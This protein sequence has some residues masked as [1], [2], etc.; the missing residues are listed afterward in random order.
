MGTPHL[1]IHPSQ[2]DLLDLPWERSITEWDDPRLADLPTGIHRHEIVFIGLDDGF[3]AIKELPLL[4]A[5]NEY[6]VLS[7]LESSDVPSVQ[8]IGLVEREWLDPQAE[9]S[10]AVIT[11][12]LAHAFSYRELISGV[13]FGQRRRQMVGGFA[14]LLVEM[15]LAGVFWGD[16]SLSN[17]LYR[18]D[19]GEIEVTMIDAE[20]SEIHP[21]LSDG[22]RAE[23]LAIMI[24]NVAGGMA[25]VAA[26]LEVDIDDA[27]LA[28]GMDIS[29]QYGELWSELTED[30]L[31]GR[32][33]RYLVRDRIAR[34]NDLGFQVED[35][36]LEPE[37]GGDRMR[38]RARVGGRSFH[39]DRLRRLTGLDASENQAR[40]I[41]SDVYYHGAKLGDEIGDSAEVNAIT[42][43]VGTFEPLLARIAD[44]L[45]EADPIQAYT[46]LLHHRFTLATAQGR[47]IPNAEAYESWVATGRP[48]YPLDTT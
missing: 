13:G 9:A 30:V 28:L 6:R 44:E 2:P 37:E 1:V 16:G 8:P 47:D 43:R 3:Y 17:V 40:Q 46:D 12:Y 48:G 20:T 14:W 29:D 10:A 35:V 41:L 11:K 33:E 34:L 32:N 25:D 31:I 22:Q 26:E 24:E 15:H 39:S 7:E 19:A 5:R 23:D 36:A 27:D 18:Y 42:W 21:A 4:P 45:P 38:L